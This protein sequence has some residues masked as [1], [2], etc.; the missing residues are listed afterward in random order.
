MVA[1]LLKHLTTLPQVEQNGWTKLHSRVCGRGS[2]REAF[3][4][5]I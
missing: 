4:M 2:A 1:S 5:M 3:G